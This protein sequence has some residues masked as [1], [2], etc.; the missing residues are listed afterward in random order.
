MSFYMGEILAIRGTPLAVSHPS[1]LSFGEQQRRVRHVGSN[2]TNEQGLYLLGG[3]VRIARVLIRNLN[4]STF[5][6]QSP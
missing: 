1:R 2:T 4:L 6:V 5:S 3:F